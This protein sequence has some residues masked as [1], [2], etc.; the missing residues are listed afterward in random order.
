MLKNRN[1]E[2][3]SFVILILMCFVYMLANVLF[4]L[5][6]DFVD[7]LIFFIAWRVMVME[8]ETRKATYKINE[9]FRC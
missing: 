8:E 2:A 5:K 7:Y 1:T 9:W 6:I 4:N 3:Q